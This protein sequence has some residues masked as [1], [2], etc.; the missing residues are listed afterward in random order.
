VQKIEKGALMA[1]NTNNTDTGN[2]PQMDDTN[3][4]KTLKL[5][6]L[7]KDTGDED[8]VEQVVDPLTVRNTETGP[9]A[10]MD[11]TRTRKTVKLK[12]TKTGIITLENTPK[13]ELKTVVDPLTMRNTETGPLGAMVD[14]RTRK[15]VKLKPLKTAGDGKEKAAA[16]EPERVKKAAKGTAPVTIEETA[17]D[18]APEAPAP[19]MQ[20]TS[21]RRT[22]KLKAVKPGETPAPAADGTMQDTSTRRTLKLKAIKPGEAPASDGAMQDTSTRRTLK[23]KA[24]K[25]GEASKTLDADAEN[26]PATMQDTNTRKTL[27]LKA[28]KPGEASKTLDADAENA[29]VTLQDTNTRK[30]LK[31]KAI[32]PDGEKKEAAPTLKPVAAPA[33]EKAPE[34]TEDKKEEDTRTRNVKMPSKGTAGTDIT[35]AS[36]DDTIKIERP[37][38]KADA[39]PMPS[40]GATAAAKTVNNKATVKLRPPADNKKEAA[41]DEA[42]AKA[43]KE[44]IKLSPPLEA[45]KEEA[46]APEEKKGKAPAE[47]TPKKS[48]LTI[49]KAPPPKTVPAETEEAAPEVKKGGLKLKSMAPAAEAPRAEADKEKIKEIKAAKKG[50]SEASMFYTMVAIISVVLVA[51]SALVTVSQFFELWEKESPVGEQIVPHIKGLMTEIMKLK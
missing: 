15:T 47:E 1:D 34:A 46:K 20:D 28:V 18:L 41:S 33:A 12:A 7:G 9:L 6:P 32:K 37:K 10:T 25:P 23:L 26:S 4:R 42:A 17:P 5:K 22:L 38:K 40:L 30:T 39:M 19:A 16:G 14:T 50:S 8:I 2:I 21:T 3:T 49:G 13:V 51:F 24:V 35:D 44:T 43:S 48:K 11:D 45:K 36:E 29:P 27:K 31:L